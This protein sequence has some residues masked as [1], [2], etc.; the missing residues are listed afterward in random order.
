MTWVVF[1]YGGVICAHQ[2]DEDVAA[3]AAAAGVGVPEFR[4]AYWPYRLSYDRADLDGSTYWQRVAA[5]LGL[6]FHASQVAELNRLDTASWLHLREGTV[7]LIEDLAAAGYRLALLS[8][9]PA[10]SARALVDLPVFR[11][12]EHVAFSCFLGTVKPE[13]ECY[14]AV[15]AMLRARPRDVIFL[16][17]RPENVA[18]ATAL[19]IHGVRF[20]TPEAARAAL[21]SL[22]VI[23]TPRG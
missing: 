6:S 15:L 13:P 23:V 10:E 2:R 18:G 8:N 11:H 5:A 7:A 14:Q 20:T 16:D 17:D 12:F 4:D 19:G 22:G 21:T 3:L 9:A 1:D